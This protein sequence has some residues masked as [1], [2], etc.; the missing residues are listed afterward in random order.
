[1]KK[2]WILALS[3]TCL[4]ACGDIPL[5]PDTGSEETRAQAKAEAAVEANASVPAAV[6]NVSTTLAG[7][8]YTYGPSLVFLNCA[9]ENGTNAQLVAAATQSRNQLRE[10]FASGD[11]RR[12]ED[13]LNRVALGATPLNFDAGIQ[14]NCSLETTSGTTPGNSP[15]ATPS[16]STGTPLRLE[17]ENAT[18]TGGILKYPVS[19]SRRTGEQ[20]MMF[21]GGDAGGQATLTLP[22]LKG[23]YVVNLSWLNTGD[24]PAMDIELDGQT[25]ALPGA[26]AFNSGAAIVK[27]ELGTYTFDID[28]GDTAT[29][30]VK[31]EVTGL[32][33]GWIG[34]DYIE[35]IPA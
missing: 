20:V 4:S 10:A 27:R 9:I 12:A 19:E 7:K 31:G 14:S 8:T 34:V 22:E 25:I 35:F 16:T 33:N 2:I 11:P 29:F 18:K 13:A 21:S 5:T 26:T 23:R 1:M 30:T 3:L 32:G 6:Q 28:A 17:V 15:T 24:S